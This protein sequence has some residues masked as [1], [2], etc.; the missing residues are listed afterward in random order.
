M[1]RKLQE[2]FARVEAW[3]EEAQEELAEL[4]LEIEAGRGGIYHATAEELAAIDDADR[5]GLATPT[6]VAA[7]LAKFR[8]A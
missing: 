3:P 5:S 1:N 7:A 2:I 4:A 8:G 6:E